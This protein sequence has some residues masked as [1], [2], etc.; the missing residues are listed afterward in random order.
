MALFTTAEAKAFVIAG[1]TPLAA[2]P[3]ATISAAEARIKERFEDICRVAFEP[4]EVTVTLDRNGANGIVLPHTRVTALEEVTVDGTEV[5]VA[6]LKL[7]DYGVLYYSTGWGNGVQDVEVTYTHGHA[8]VPKAI[9]WA[10]LVVA[11]EEIV[12]S[13]I[14][15]RATSHTDDLG[16]FRLSVPDGERERWYGIPA[17]DAIL[18]QYSEKVPAIG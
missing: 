12:G 15:K 4:T 2:Y 8:T 13:D 3:D 1:D 6:D 16:T 17:V 9:K 7:Y 18:S 11:V 5:D 14:T 10:A